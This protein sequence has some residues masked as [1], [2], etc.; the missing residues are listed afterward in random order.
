MLENLALPQA[1]P[2]L[3]S[4]FYTHQTTNTGIYE[5]LRRDIEALSDFT[6]TEAVAYKNNQDS[7][8]AWLW[9]LTELDSLI[10]SASPSQIPGLM[11]EKSTRISALVSLRSP[12]D[13]YRSAI[14]S[15]KTTLIDQLIARNSAL[16]TNEVFY[17]NEKTCNEVFLNTIAK[18]IYTLTTQQVAQ[19]S[20][21]AEQC[22]FSGGR[23]V[24][25][26]RGMYQMHIDTIF[27]DA[28]GGTIPYF[29]AGLKEGLLEEIDFSFS[30]NPA[31]LYVTVSILRGNPTEFILSDLMG[32]TV[33]SIVVPENER[34]LLIPLEELSAGCYFLSARSGNAKS[35]ISKKMLINR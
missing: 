13:N 23:A 11:V 4:F 22:A 21:I 12:N 5:T 17:E 34:Q 7:I 32:K 27:F 35:T 20:P 6:S 30:P 26:A 33:S 31:H 18:G 14:Q 2:S 10:W 19:L 8:I 1:H 3:Q 16:S 15:Q 28:C 24:Y 9:I 25:Q 29:S